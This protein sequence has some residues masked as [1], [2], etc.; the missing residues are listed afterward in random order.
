MT[1][2]FACSLLPEALE[3][4]RSWRQDGRRIV[5]TNGCFD[6]L[7]PGHVHYLEAA[8]KLGNILI[9]GLNDDDSVRR[10]NKGAGRP[11]NPLADRAC[12]LAALK[13]VDM[14][15]PFSEDTPLELIRALK[16]DVLVKGGDYMPDNIV[17]AS[18]VKGWGGTV[19]TI[20]FVAG[21]ST[22]SLINSIQQD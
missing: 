18:E 19:T 9:I 3:R 13:P 7:H 20:P 5:F 4:I 10:L 16:P 17:G 11:L 8:K 22:T 15:V 14:V 21:Y 2:P 6:I 1:K 12:L